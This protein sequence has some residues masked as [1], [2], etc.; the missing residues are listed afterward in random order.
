MLVNSRERQN[1]I[2]DEINV[3]DDDL[4]GSGLEIRSCS[5]V[6]T[7]ENCVG[8]SLLWDLLNLL[9]L[10]VKGTHSSHLCPPRLV[11]K[12]VPGSVYFLIEWQSSMAQIKLKVTIKK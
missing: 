6:T 11:N 3:S 5:V 4:E 7:Q 10:S 1:F 9:H 12:S 2:R 8:A